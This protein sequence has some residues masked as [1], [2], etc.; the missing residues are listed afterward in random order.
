MSG[1]GLSGGQGIASARRPRP[2]PAVTLSHTGQ[3]VKLQLKSSVRPS[4]LAR[5]IV[6]LNNSVDEKSGCVPNVE[7]DDDDSAAK[8]RRD[9]TRQ[10]SV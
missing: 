1:R 2:W 7:G 6:P 8:G 9:K 5:S 4:F 3:F 10:S